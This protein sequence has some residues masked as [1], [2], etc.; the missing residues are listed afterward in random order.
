MMDG[1]TEGRTSGLS[2]AATR[3]APTF[4]DAGKNSGFE[5]NI[6]Q[7]DVRKKYRLTP[8]KY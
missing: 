5:V 3:T 7:I 2:Q 6:F 8:L 1:Q 4:G